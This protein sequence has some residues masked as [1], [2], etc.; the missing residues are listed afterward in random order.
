ML[1]QTNDNAHPTQL[2]CKVRVLAAL[3]SATQAI[4]RCR[5]IYMYV[6]ARIPRTASRHAR[7]SI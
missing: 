7:A 4:G 2:G 3:N 5:D 1:H 6:A